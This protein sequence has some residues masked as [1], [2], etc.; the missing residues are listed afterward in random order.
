MICIRENKGSKNLNTIAH[1]FFYCT[2]LAF[3]VH[4][5]MLFVFLQWTIGSKGQPGGSAVKKM[6][7]GS[8]KKGRG[9]GGGGKMIVQRKS[10]SKKLPLPSSSDSS[11]DDEEDED[12][13]PQ[14]LGSS[15]SEGSS[16]DSDSSS[17]QFDDGLDE[18]L[19]G[20]EEDQ[21]KLSLM[22]ETEREVEMYKR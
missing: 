3:S 9:G 13:E 7:M 2:Y 15:S 5:R 19:L 12:D 17:E 18:N 14:K 6:A 4:I 10:T 21:K 11:E 1:C 22:N 8:A 20:D 16:S